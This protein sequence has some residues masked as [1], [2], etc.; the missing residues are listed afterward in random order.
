[1]SQPEQP[2]TLYLFWISYFSGK[3]QAYLRYKRIAHVEIEAQ[4]SGELMRDVLPNTGLMKVPA[5][6]TPQGQW[7]ADTTPMIDWFETRH[8]QGSVIPED[9]YQAFFSRLLEDY[10][11]EWLWRPALHYRWSYANDS[12]ALSRR[13]AETFLSR[14]P[15]PAPLIAAM[16]RRRQRRIYVDGDGVTAAT[17][18]HVESIY[19]NT[20]DRLQALFE[21]Q[22]YLLGGRP[23]LADFG[24][25]ASMFRHF[26]LDP[27]PSLIMQQRAPAVLAWVARMWNARYDDARLG[28]WCAPGTLPDGW[29]PLL[30]DVGS[31]YLPYLLAN[32]R[33]WRDGRRRFDVEIQGTL[34]RR[35]PVVQY[36]VWC[37]ERLQQHRTALP[38]AVRALVD[39]RLQQ[40]GALDVLLADGTIASGL[41]DDV[42]P[43]VCRPRRYGAAERLRRFFTGTHWHAPK[44]RAPSDGDTR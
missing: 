21:H 37:R 26:S 1:M 18:A 30:D 11:D 15:L 12:H 27:T 42:T 2:Y 17:R 14:H 36:R 19:L 44:T 13:F 9:A 22:D 5:I 29:G 8:P 6:R 34:Y 10:A 28:S 41:Y 20:L 3:M 38:E 40:A 43:P 4:W 23:S 25:F 16:V 35:L 39:A 31:G 33:A 24:F 32:A 7:L